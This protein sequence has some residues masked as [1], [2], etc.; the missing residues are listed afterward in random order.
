MVTSFLNVKFEK[1][2]LYFEL[3]ERK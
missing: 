3:F 2:L 1:I